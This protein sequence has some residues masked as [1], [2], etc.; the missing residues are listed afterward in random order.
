MNNWISVADQRPPH[1][2][3][4]V[5]GDGFIEADVDFYGDLYDDDGIAD[6]NEYGSNVT[7]WMP[8]PEPPK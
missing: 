4:L 8:L 5:W 3:V 2:H 7:H 6:F 1:G